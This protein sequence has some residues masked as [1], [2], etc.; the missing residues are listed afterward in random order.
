MA[1]IDAAFGLRPVGHL[2]G[3]P[4]NGKVT[5][6]LIPA[7]DGSTVFVGDYVIKEATVGAGAAGLV[8]GGQDC[9]GMPTVIRG[10]ASSGALVAGVVVGFLP[11]PGSLDT[12]HRVAST[13]RVALV[14][15]SP[16][17]VFEIQE[18]SEGNNLAADQVGNNFDPATYA[19]GSTLTGNSITELDS[20]DSTGTSTAML[21]LLGL[22]KRPGN[23][24]GTNA[25]WL[26][27]FNEHMYKTT[28][29][30]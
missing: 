19:A 21:R 15:D 11:L 2:D 9:E 28:T 13:N 23:A 14:V 20:S 6:Y 26:V 7:A 29:G 17:V 4:F 24:I 25:K 30:I 22:S 8:V 10:A 16:D 12:R 27:V 3:S 1:N 18:D 5:Q